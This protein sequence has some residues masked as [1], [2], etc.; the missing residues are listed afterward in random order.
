LLFD[1]FSYFVEARRPNYV[2]D[3]QSDCGAESGLQRSRGD[4]GLIRKLANA[5]VE[6]VCFSYLFGRVYVHEWLVCLE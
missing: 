6:S 1:E 5:H 3:A 4:T 2:A